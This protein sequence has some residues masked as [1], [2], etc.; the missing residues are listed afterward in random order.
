VRSK[1][2]SATTVE[3][4]TVVRQP[5]FKGKCPNLQGHI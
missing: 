2:R 5:G 4:P 1:N 3:K